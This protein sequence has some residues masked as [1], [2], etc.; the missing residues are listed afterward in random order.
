MTI[1]SGGGE[2]SLSTHQKKDVQQYVYF[3]LF[4]YRYG[5]QNL[6]FFFQ[7]SQDV[8]FVEYSINFDWNGS[9]TMTKRGSQNVAKG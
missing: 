5:T 1:M 9:V 3:C 7:L 4:F 6:I 2:L 8:V